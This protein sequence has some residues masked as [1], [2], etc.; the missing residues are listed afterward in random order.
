MKRIVITIGRQTGSGGREIGIKIADR[1]GIPFYDQALISKAAETAD[2]SREFIKAHDE[3]K[4]SS[5]L[6]SIVMDTLSINPNLPSADKVFLAQ[7]NAIKEIAK[8]GSCVI[9][10]RCGDYA[11]ENDPDLLSIFLYADFDFRTERIKKELGCS[12]AEAKSTI[13]KTDKR[14][15]G[16]YNHYT[17]KKWA[18]IKGFDLGINTSRFGIDA[19][20]DMI[21]NIALARAGE[22][23]EE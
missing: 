14:R 19:C 12:T 22:Q 23:P 2:L 4:A 5:L 8:E 1:L 6:Y 21:C 20:V 7:F 10:G 18:D 3:Q 9:V 16:Y 17:G 15:S 11:L 13:I